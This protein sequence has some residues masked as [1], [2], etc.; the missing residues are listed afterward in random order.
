M[1]VSSASSF[2]VN[3][4]LAPFGALQPQPAS[5]WKGNHP[6]HP[7]LV[8]FYAEVGPYGDV[9]PD[10][11][12]GLTIPTLGNPFWLPPLHMLWDIQAGYGSDART[13]QP[14]ADWRDEW[15]V[16]ADQ[17]GDPFILDRTSGSILHDRHGGGTWQPTLMF[18]DIFVM[19]LALA[20][21]GTLHEQAG[22]D[23]YDADYAI[24]P[25][26]RAA[27]RTQL[28]RLLGTTEG[29]AVATRLEW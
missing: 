23:L 19:A 2:S 15:V 25:A 24:K 4:A 6:L 18:A 12:D 22:E 28:A 26:W 7:T 11:P 17:G 8:S 27:L 14:S 21:I 1:S 5:E 10:G 29:N 13:G 3:D 16:V 9:G 20:T